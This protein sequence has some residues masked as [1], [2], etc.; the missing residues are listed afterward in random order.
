MKRTFTILIAIG[1]IAIGAL[2]VHSQEDMTHVAPNGFTDPMRPAARFEHDTH[3]ETAELDDC[4]VCHHV[5]D[6]DGKRVEDE[7]SEDSACT[8]C[9]DDSAA[10]LARRYHKACKSCHFEQKAG[11][12]MCGQCHRR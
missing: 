9:H 10:N 11:P 2:T 3:N 1:L 8:D 5:Y 7:S 4:A 12:V 6:D